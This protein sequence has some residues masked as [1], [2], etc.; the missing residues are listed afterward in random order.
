MDRSQAH[1]LDRALGVVRACERAC[2]RSVRTY[3]IFS[4]TTTKRS[5][6]KSQYIMMQYR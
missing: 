5:T 4:S 6:Q 2:E 3:L 1:S